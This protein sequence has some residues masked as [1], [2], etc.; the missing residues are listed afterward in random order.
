[1][2]HLSEAARLQKP[3]LI[4]EFNLVP[5]RSVSD[6][7][8]FL[9]QIYSDLQ[10]AA[11]AGQPVAGMSPTCTIVRAYLYE[12]TSVLVLDSIFS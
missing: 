4:G 3:L 5:F 2:A 11:A 7:N 10:A 6:R 12:C 9:S 8:A 1:M